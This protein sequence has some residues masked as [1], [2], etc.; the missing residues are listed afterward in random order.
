MNRNSIRTFESATAILTG[1]AS[2]IGRAL[3][4]ELATRGCE[5]VVTDLQD[6]LAEEVAAGIR[7]SGGKARAEKLDVCDFDAVDRLVQ[8]TIDR[9]GRLDYMFNNAGH[10]CIDEWCQAGIS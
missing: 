8:D 1:G 2:G 4:Q 6:E 5:V 10:H 7:A 3:A 9:T